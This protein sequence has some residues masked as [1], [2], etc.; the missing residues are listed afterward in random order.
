MLKFSQSNGENIQDPP[1]PL[2][3]AEVQSQPVERRSR[4]FPRVLA[5][6][7]RDD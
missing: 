7:R 2:A 4:I 3:E 6:D 1:D 5:R